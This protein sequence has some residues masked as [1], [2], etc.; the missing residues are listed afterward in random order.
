MY[1]VEGIIINT[2]ASPE[3]I[4]IINFS[5]TLADNPCRRRSVLDLLI[6]IF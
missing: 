6:N 4:E 5:L 1:W 3:I 2:P